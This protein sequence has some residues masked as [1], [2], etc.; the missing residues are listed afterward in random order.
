MFAVSSSFN[1]QPLFMME[2]AATCMFDQ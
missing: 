2:R 1:T